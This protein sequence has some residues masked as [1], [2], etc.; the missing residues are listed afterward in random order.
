[1]IAAMSFLAFVADMDIVI[2]G[3]GLYRYRKR[4]VADQL[5]RWSLFVLEHS[6]VGGRCSICD[7]VVKDVMWNGC[8]YLNKS[9]VLPA[10]AALSYVRHRLII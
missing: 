8:G 10:P 6:L 1:M 4:D 2:W 5:R 7:G 9:L 3:L